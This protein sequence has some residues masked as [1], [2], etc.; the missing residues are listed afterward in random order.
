MLTPIVP[1]VKPRNIS[2]MS[3]V[4]PSRR[5]ASGVALETPSTEKLVI[6]E[7]NE[8]NRKHRPA[9]AGFMKLCPSP[10]KRHLATSTAKRLPR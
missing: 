9:S 5:T 2:R 7:P 1:L 3:T 10:P 6:A 4:P 8:I